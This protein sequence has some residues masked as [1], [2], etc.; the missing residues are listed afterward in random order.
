[1]RIAILSALFLA[2]C[3]NSPDYVARQ[4]NYDVC[5]LTMG[6]PHSRNA[7]AEAARRG[8]DCAPLYPAIQAREGARDA[9]VQNYLRST[10]PAPIPQPRSCTSYRVGNTV[11]TDCQ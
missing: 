4:S 5:R 7:E 11:Q 1:M 8:V 9:A 10:Q 2:G 3:A 6:G